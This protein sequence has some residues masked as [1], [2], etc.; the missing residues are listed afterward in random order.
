MN[1]LIHVKRGKMSEMPQ[2]KLIKY[3]SSVV[4]SFGKPV[5]PMIAGMYGGWLITRMPWVM[6]QPKG[7]HNT[8]LKLACNIRQTLI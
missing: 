2:F 8:G 4:P 1:T 7:L 5:L 6:N 3:L